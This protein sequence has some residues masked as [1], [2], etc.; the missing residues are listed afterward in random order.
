MK[1]VENEQLTMIKLEFA[2]LKNKKI[3]VYGSGENAKLLIE[4]LQGFNI[5]GILDRFRYEGN[6]QAI[7]ILT[8]D[9]IDKHT[10]D[11][12]IIASN[13]KNFREIFLR[14]K[15]Y[16]VMFDMDIYSFSGQN[17][18]SKFYYADYS[19]E[20]MQCL[21][22]SKQDLL[23]K[24]DLYDVI[25][26]DLFDTLIMR[27]VLEPIDIF[28]IVERKI[29]K[30]G[31]NIQNFKKKRRTA[32]L[33]SNGSDIFA[34]YREL[35]KIINVSDKELSLIMK[36]E[37]ECEKANIISRYDMVEV[38]NYSL[39]KGKIVSIISNMYL[40]CDIVQ[41]I[42]ENI[43]IRGYHHLL[44]SCEYGK[45]K[46]EGLFEIYKEKVGNNKKCLHI[47]DD[48]GEDILAAEKNGITAFYINSSLELLK[49]S[50]IH[51]LLLNTH[52]FENRLL[53]GL[54]ISKLFNNPFI[55]NNT[56]G[57]VPL[58]S[59][60]T[61][62][63]V[64]IAPVVYIYMKQLLNCI[65]QNQY[66]GIIFPA[67][68]GYIF[69]YLYNKY[70]EKDN[71]LPQGYY[72]IISRKIAEGISQYDA[73]DVI[74]TSKKYIEPKRNINF[75]KQVMYFE[76]DN[77]EEIIKESKEKRNVYTNYIKKQQID[78]EKRYLFCELISTGTSQYALNQIFS[79]KLYGFYL[80]GI[81]LLPELNNMVTYVYPC[82][83]KN[84]ITSRADILEAIL[85]SPQ[86]SAA[87]INSDEDIFYESEER[88]EQEINMMINIHKYVGKFIEEFECIC[89]DL[90]LIDLSLPD[91]LLTLLDGIK[92][93]GDIEF[94]K[95]GSY[96]ETMTLQK[97]N[98]MRRL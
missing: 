53:V 32:E 49:M 94:L 69:S 1:K 68:D 44:I 8:W 60:K 59:V 18:S 11:V 76:S 83:L 72:I 51:N 29:K 61:F 30:Y 89:E 75:W 22:Y 74:Q 70:K 33:N 13:R 45:A 81:P 24:I 92:I 86:S 35:K 50:K 17:L 46:S 64:F 38:F 15:H 97:I 67:R 4:A 42:L 40:P 47:G 66:D 78:L 27:K 85:S 20:E 52:G 34:I 23:N 79:H 87:G 48:Y 26:F 7:P 21:E 28:D 14:I 41:S 95:K 2:H 19:Y 57:Y 56:S 39:Q 9:D 62:S 12:I 93:F 25:S 3:L 77:I 63:E 6:I 80:G 16:G 43:G 84:N 10:A 90:E 54:I 96:D 31:I 91:N 71:T 98:I 37:L 65:H 82:G 5:I 36:E 73:D 55:L 88:T 58:S